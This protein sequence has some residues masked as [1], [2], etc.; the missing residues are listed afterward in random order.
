[1]R[2]TLFERLTP[3]AIQSL[4]KARAEGHTIAVDAIEKSLQNANYWGDLR[5]DDVRRLVLFT[6][7]RWELLGGDTYMQLVWGI[8]DL[9]DNEENLI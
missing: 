9:I 2:K 6:E 5:V 8:E 4:A 1:M 7:K 3:R